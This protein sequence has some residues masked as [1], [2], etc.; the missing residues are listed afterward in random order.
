MGDVSLDDIVVFL[1]YVSVNEFVLFGGLEVH[2]VV[3]T[4][5]LLYAFEVLVKEDVLEDAHSIVEVVVFLVL[6]YNR[7]LSPDSQSQSLPSFANMNSSSSS[8]S[9]PKRNSFVI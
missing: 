4:E 8:I 2:A 1:E 6:T 3:V 7:P 5:S 9:S